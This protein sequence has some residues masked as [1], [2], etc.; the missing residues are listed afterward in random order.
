[1]KIDLVSLFGPTCKRYR[2]PIAN[3]KGW[4]DLHLRAAIMK[5]FKD[6]EAEGRTP[7][8]LYCGDHDP[9]GLLISQTLPKQ[10][11]DMS[12][13]GGWSPDHLVV[14]RFG[15]NFDFIEEHRL[16]WIGNLETGSGGNLASPDHASHDRAY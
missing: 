3:A 11:S 6:G 13:A 7:V 8:L 2:I 14:D 1:E 9:A 4:A 5:Y 15:L 16:S 10:F 12:R